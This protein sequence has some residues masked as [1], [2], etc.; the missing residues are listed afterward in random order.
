[1]RLRRVLKTALKV[2]LGLVA[3]ALVVFLA[4][5]FWTHPKRSTDSFYVRPAGPNVFKLS[6][7]PLQPAPSEGQV[8]GYVDRLLAE[9]SLEERV[10]QMSGDTWLFDLVKLV[11]VG[12]YKYNDRAILA[13]RNRRLLVPPLAFSDGPRGVVMNHS[14]AFPVAMAR[15]ASFDR[16]LELRIG[17]AI[18]QELRAQGANLFGGVCINLLRHPGWGRAQETYGEDPYLLGEMG[19]A[20]VAG[21]QRHN[22][23]AC[24]KHF[25]LNSIEESRHFVDVRV[26]ERA[27]REVYLPHFERVVKA[28]AAAVMS[29]YNR[30]NGDY[31]A[32][33]R[34]LLREILKD[35]WGFSGFV[36]SD[37]FRGVY[38][39][40]K[41]AN[42][43][44]DV[45]M[46]MT[47]RYGA[48]LLA[49][50]AEGEVPRERIDDAVRRI[51]R[52][53]VYYATRP[54]PQ[55]YDERLVRSQAHVALA[56][57]AAEKSMVLLKNEAGALPFERARVR[58]LAV[59][60]HLADGA[61]NLGDHGSSRVYP[62]EV[63]SPLAGL[64][65]Y[66]GP[67]VRVVH[68]L[69]G[70]MARVRQLAR[71]ADAVIVVAGL[72][73]R[74]EGEHIPEKPE[75]DRGGDRRSLGLRDEEIQVIQAVSALN[76]RTA[77]VLIGGS[78]IV[79]EE[80][81]NEAPAILMAFYPGQEGGRALARLLF[82]ELSPSGKLPFTVPA[83]ASWLP[84]FDPQ[85][86]RVE[87]G[88]YHGYTLAEKKGIE[89]AFAFGFG[90]SYTRF[91][92]AHLRLDASDIPPEGQ[93]AVSVDV[94]NAGARAGEEVAQLY[95]AF[96]A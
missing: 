84:S 89:P 69:G 25:A 31:A 5:D 27:L 12:G 80:W 75:G 21:V 50:L 16:S 24:V 71:E 18:G 29:S 42:A 74:D 66:L 6:D 7:V 94:T 85:A 38:D 72:D 70:D 33:S 37:F 46:P 45:E 20:L 11:T 32:E 81:R 68:E 86:E 49:A 19:S 52:R 23:M 95:A 8:E 36:L 17:D 67:G 51:L 9:M 44:L 60:G 53:K 13:G 78:A 63:V 82:G 64:R 87:Y 39:G 62:P 14:T 43:G 83:D 54:D 48:Q 65:E 55:A 47:E 28:G 59:L 4:Y 76:Q 2:L 26:D 88:Y 77:V 96:K 61:E 22:V 35:E 91:S 34:H 30:V 56:R 41:A 15:G 93:V 73:H 58:T 1:M 3:F 79:M 40:A 92:Y 90:L 57:E 10:Q